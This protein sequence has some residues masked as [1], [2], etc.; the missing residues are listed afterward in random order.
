MVYHLQSQLLQAQF[1]IVGLNQS[2]KVGRP[3]WGTSK[4][5]NFI[6]FVF[7]LLCVGFIPNE[8]GKVQTRLHFYSC[9]PFQVFVV[10]LRTT[11][12]SSDFQSLKFNLKFN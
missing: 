12:F 10:F 3:A 9:G 8:H 1:W 7:T 5:W 4:S 6:H 2:V 11:A